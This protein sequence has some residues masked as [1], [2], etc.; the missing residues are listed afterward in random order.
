ME[1]PD[2]SR[3]SARNAARSGI[4]TAVPSI[5]DRAFQ[6]IRAWIHEVAGIS[7]SSQKKA[8]VMGRL[9]ARL[10]HYQ[11][12]SYGEYFR[13]L[14]SGAQPAEVQVAIDRLTT[15]ETQFFREPKHFDF[16]RERILPLRATRHVF[17]AWSAAASSGEEPYSIAMTIA[18]A[19]GDAPWELIA[20]DL[21]SRVLERARTGHY[22]L[23][24]ANNIPRPLLQAYCLKGIGTQEGTFL[25]EPRLRSRMRF[26]QINLI[27]PLPQIGAFDVIFVRNVMIYF[28]MPTK[29]DVVARVLRHL[30]PS[31]YLIVGHSETLNGVTDV[32]EPVV[33]S[34]YR[35][36]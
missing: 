35:K 16:L 27:E 3:P 23:G 21:S 34:V 11:L 6:D 1:A 9:A 25:I 30:R 15:N 7:L 22:S 5:D 18:A 33:P 19:L 29:R 10:K 17:R 36:R 4:A 12:A 13:L 24:R 28:D 26:E 14:K 20:S 31:G 2:G 32:L 8:L